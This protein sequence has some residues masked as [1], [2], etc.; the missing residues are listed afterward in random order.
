[1]R[2]SKHRRQKRRNPV[3]T[4]RPRT[5]E[6][7]LGELRDLTQ[8]PGYAHAFA[9]LVL[10]SN[11]AFSTGEEFT[12]EDFLKLHNPEN[13]LRTEADLVLA[14]MI[15]AP[16]DL[17]IPNP[18]TTQTYI[19]STIRL[20]AELHQAILASARGEWLKAFHEL[21]SSDEVRKSPLKNGLILREAMFYGPE[22]AFPFQYLAMAKER[23]APDSAWLQTHVGFD[24]DEAARFMEGVQKVLRPRYVSHGER[25][26]TQSPDEWTFLPNFRFELAE[27]A[28]AAG[29]ALD[30]A[31]VIAKRFST[32]EQDEELSI[33]SAFAYN[34]V[35]AYPLIR[36]RDGQMFAFSEYSLFE[37]LYNDPFYWIAKDKK[38]LGEH[39]QTRGSFVELLT[40]RT[41]RRV[42]GE[43]NV[44]RGVRFFDAGGNETAEADAVLRFGNRAFIFQAKSKKLTLAS[45]SG[46]DDAIA[47]DFKGAVQDAYDQAVACTEAIRRGERAQVG[48]ELVSS[49]FLSGAKRFYPIC[50]V[51]DHYPSLSFQA[52]ELL[53]THDQ[54]D[55]ASPIVLDVFALDVL[56]EM[57]STPLYFT[58]YLSKRADFGE[59]VMAS[60]EMVVLSWYLKQNLFV[61]PNEH[62]VLA[63][64]FLVELDLAMAV[65]RAGVAGQATPSGQLTRFRDTPIQRIIDAV[66]RSE[67]ADVHRL[68]EVVLA[69]GSEAADQLSRGM[70]RILEQTK[71]DGRAHD[72][73][74]GLEGE[75]GFTV[76]CNLFEPDR[77][78]ERLLTHCTMRKYVEKKAAW[79][80]VNVSLDGEPRMMLGL[81]EPW[82]F[83]PVLESEAGDYR[84][85]NYTH[86]LNGP[87]G[88]I[89][90]NDPCPCLSGLKYKRCHGR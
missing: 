26:R 71:L 60:H 54:P 17:A 7:V 61:K 28:D 67:R 14:L 68:G 22:S 21:A 46:D 5:Q 13:M 56:S 40:E 41:L 80:G 86:A 35:S 1:M 82:A 20:L 48:D 29:L 32:Q 25:C 76:H 34:K 85:R 62:Y 51:S 87:K 65:R 70:S 69:M 19:D 23:Y 27:V 16:V 57:L 58:D 39:S 81:E 15:S 12:K 78:R 36:L 50:I 30:K 90:R 89:G 33:R 18:F 37:S 75:A 11:V 84:I 79:Y 59:R 44:A 47:R 72:I 73:T 8:S 66:E 6:V 38:Y 45:R 9:Y 49:E 2:K 24:I 55:L 43:R 42:F 53:T 3:H 64:D 83:D 4:I 10:K 52:R 74:I 31:E 77:A 63:D 88:K